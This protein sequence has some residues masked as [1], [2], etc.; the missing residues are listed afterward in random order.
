MNVTERDPTQEIKDKV[1][2]QLKSSLDKT[3]IDEK[4]HKELYPDASQNL[5]TYGYGLGQVS[6]S[7]QNFRSPY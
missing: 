6:R 4:L 2:T 1:L 3:I 7:L 5:R